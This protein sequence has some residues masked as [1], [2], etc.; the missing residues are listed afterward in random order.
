MSDPRYEKTGDRLDHLVEECAELIKAV[1]K[2]KRFGLDNPDPRTGVSNRAQ[3]LDEISDLR[4]RAD[5]ARKEL[6]E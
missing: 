3:I 2:A 4:K 6:G 5:E 1:M